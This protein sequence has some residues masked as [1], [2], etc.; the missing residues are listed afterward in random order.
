MVEIQLEYNA[1]LTSMPVLVCYGLD[2]DRW[3][4]TG[5]HKKDSPHF[6]DDIWFWADF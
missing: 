5:L 4:C 6:D 2:G 3:P 1:P